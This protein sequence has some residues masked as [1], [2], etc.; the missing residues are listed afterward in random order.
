MSDPF[1]EGFPCSTASQFPGQ[2]QWLHEPMPGSVTKQP[3]ESWLYDM[4]F[5]PRLATAETITSITSIGQEKLNTE[6]LERT[7]S[8]DLT[9]SNQAATGQVA[10]CRISGGT[11]GSVYVVT[12]KVGTSLG[13]A[14]EA[15]GLLVVTDT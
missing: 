9:I 1:R 10:Q 5:A 3:S 13:N 6:T 14:A 12:F 7:T 8:T 11:N 2:P 15:E 4:D